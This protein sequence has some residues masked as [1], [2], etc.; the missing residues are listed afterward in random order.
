VIQGR[1]KEGNFKEER[2]SL[3]SFRRRP[4]KGKIASNEQASHEKGRGIS[5]D[6]SAKGRL[7]GRH[8]E[9]TVLL[10]GQEILEE[11]VGDK[12]K[13]AKGEERERR[14][15]VGKNKGGGGEKGRG[16]AVEMYELGKG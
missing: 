7:I 1:G 4:S 15:G 6:R 2:P 9:K 5:Q 10:E 14:G 11:G 16:L 13:S 8:R 3:R 12:M